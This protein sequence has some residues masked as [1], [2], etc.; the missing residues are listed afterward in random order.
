MTLLFEKWNN[1]KLPV[2]FRKLGE[3]KTEQCPYCG[4]K[5][6]HGYDDGHRIAHCKDKD[7][8]LINPDGLQLTPE[9]GYIIRHI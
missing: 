5:H 8:K 9:Q 1:K 4:L 3:V 7:L 2:I 6:N